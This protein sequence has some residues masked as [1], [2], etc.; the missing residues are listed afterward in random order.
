MAGLTFTQEDLVAN[1]EGHLTEGQRAQL[2]FALLRDSFLYGLLAL[3]PLGGFVVVLSGSAEHPVNGTMLA[4]FAI[5]FGLLVIFI[6]NLIRLTLADLAGVVKVA[7]G[8]AALY[9]SGRGL[10]SL[11][12][13]QQNFQISRQIYAD[14]VDGTYYRVYYAPRLKQILSVELAEY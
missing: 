11:S 6:A 5:L 13:G 10:R 9:D 8:Q 1:R 3:L 4:I 14:F 7:T 2:R 12:I